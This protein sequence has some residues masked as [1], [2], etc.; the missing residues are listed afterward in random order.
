MYFDNIVI[1]MNCTTIHIILYVNG[2]RTH[3]PL[4]G[5][6]A[7]FIVMFLWQDTVLLQF[8]SPCKNINV[9]CQLKLT[10]KP[11]GAGKPYGGVHV[12]SHPE[13]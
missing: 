13:E 10:W 3:C 11:T 8:F 9:Y 4:D 12:A 1:E 7:T 2:N 6:Q 5:V